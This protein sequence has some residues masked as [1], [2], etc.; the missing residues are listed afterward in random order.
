[1]TQPDNVRD[2]R[3]LFHVDVRSYQ[4]VGAER[5]APAGRALRSEPGVKSRRIGRHGAQAP[6]RRTRGPTHA[7]RPSRRP[8]RFRDR[9]S[10]GDMLA[11]P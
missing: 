9:A 4:H 6:P 7:H 11:L 3:A 10:N 5:K 2:A 8:G 1:M